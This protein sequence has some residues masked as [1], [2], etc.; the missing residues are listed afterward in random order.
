MLWTLHD[1]VDHEVEFAGI[2]L[3]NDGHLVGAGNDVRIVA[4]NAA[5]I[6]D[7]AVYGRYPTF[8][9]RHP[10]RDIHPGNVFALTAPD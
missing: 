4:H 8:I 5:L 2:L 1:D 7:E 10:P 3:P 6:D 9:L